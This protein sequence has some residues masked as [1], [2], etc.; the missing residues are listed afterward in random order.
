MSAIGP[1]D[2]D[3]FRECH[4]E[5]LEAAET[6]VRRAKR[7]IPADRWATGADGAKLVAQGIFA[8]QCIIAWQT[9]L[10]VSLAEEAGRKGVD[11]IDIHSKDAKRG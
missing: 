8:M 7:G 10:L 4:A 3:A 9:D 1:D 5:A 11:A 2:I 6:Y